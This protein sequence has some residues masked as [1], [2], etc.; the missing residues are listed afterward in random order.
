M[1]WPRN[2][3]FHLVPAQENTREE[4]D[5]T[6]NF[7]GLSN[8]RKTK[9]GSWLRRLIGVEVKKGWKKGVILVADLVMNNPEKPS[10]FDRES[11]SSQM[12]TVHS[13]WAIMRQASINLKKSE[14]KR[15]K[16]KERDRE[17]KELGDGRGNG[18]Q[19]TMRKDKKFA[20]KERNN[21]SLNIFKYRRK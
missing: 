3:I 4:S 9:R 12:P 15:E 16:E 8:N 21:K 5:K 1:H 7:L 11:D 13:F 17:R 19:I 18:P 2:S 20:S 6:R 10:G 14:W